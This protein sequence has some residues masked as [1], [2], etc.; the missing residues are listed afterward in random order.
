MAVDEVVN[1]FTTTSDNPSPIPPG[2]DGARPRR[3]GLSLQEMMASIA[4]Y[5]DTL[6]GVTGSLTLSGTDPRASWNETDAAANNKFWDILPVAEQYRMRIVNDAQNVFTN[7]LTV[8]RTGTTVDLIDLRATTVRATGILDVTGAITVGG[9]VDG[10]DVDGDG[11]KL[12]TIESSATA[13]QTA[14]EIEAIVNHDNLVGFVGGEHFLESSIDHTAISNIGSNS[15]SA[16]DTHIAD[17]TLHFTEAS[18]S[19]TE[20]QISD[21]STNKATTTQLEDNTNAINTDAAKVLGYAVLNTTTGVTV[22]A[23]GSGDSDTWDFY[24]ATTAHTPI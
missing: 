7:W 1:W 11:T 9:T 15:H 2:P 22:F 6:S 13:D 19:I 3:V 16:I 18:I 8:D 4:R 12:D 10:R 20:S 14:G 21:L 23:A 17:G 5:R 24:D